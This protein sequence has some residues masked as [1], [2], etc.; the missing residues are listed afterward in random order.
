MERP[1]DTQTIRCVVDAGAS[2][3]SPAGQEAHDAIFQAA[4]ARLDAIGRD[5]AEALTALGAY[6]G[7]AA[8]Q[9]PSPTRIQGPMVTAPIPLR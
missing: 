7:P 8:E 6:V 1:G 9:L 3:V 4:H 5:W 2:P